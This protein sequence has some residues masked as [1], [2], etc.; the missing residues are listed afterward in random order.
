MT[1]IE[2]GEL[3]P[4]DVTKDDI[5]KSIR[6]AQTALQSAGT[7]LVKYRT[8]IKAQAARIAELEEHV[9]FLER[10]INRSHRHLAADNKAVALN[11]LRA[12]ITKEKEHGKDEGTG[13]SAV[14]RD[15][16]SRSDYGL[17]ARGKSQ[18][19]KQLDFIWKEGERP[20]LELAFTRERRG[21]RYLKLIEQLSEDSTTFRAWWTDIGQ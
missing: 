10:S 8:I 16:E 13:H 20:E 7:N 14:P 19:V 18:L 9:E 2:H 5:I 21:V 12:Y 11:I 6:D 1:S 4:N 3:P 15:G 17:A